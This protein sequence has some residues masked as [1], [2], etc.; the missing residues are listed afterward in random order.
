MK[1]A[2]RAPGRVN[3]IGDHTDYNQGLVL[4]IAIQYEVVVTVAP[5]DK[6]VVRA[7]EEDETFE[8]ISDGSVDP[9]LIELDWGRL[10]A[11]LLQTLREMGRKDTGVDIEISSSVPRGS[12]LASS[13]AFEVACALSLCHVAGLAIDPWQL[14]TACRDAEEIA[15]GVP[16]G[17]MD[18]AIS[19]LARRGH[20]LSLDCEDLSFIHVPLPKDVAFVVLHTGIS[21][22][23]QASEYGA[24]RKACE[25]AAKALGLPSL[26]KAR[27]DQV[28]DDPLARH[29]V[30]ENARVEA[31]VESLKE[32]NLERLGRLFSESHASLRDDF[33]VSSPELDLATFALEQAGAAG[34]RLTGAG[35]GGCA[36]AVS[37]ESNAVSV[38]ASAVDKLR[39]QLPQAWG[40]IAYPVEGGSEITTV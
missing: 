35:F 39:R 2:F 30:S 32:G 12:G 37:T 4:P 24:R 1:R 36:V 20:A 7:T 40:F 11:A 18:Q 22:Q 21:R 3:L 5:N 15:T 29:V 9:K 13:A 38:L 10:I 23:L 6:G 19:V 34:A 26:R 17:I 25:D 14:I 31:A 33:R 8:I 27:P 16:C 28:S